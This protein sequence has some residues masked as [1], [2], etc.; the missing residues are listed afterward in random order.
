MPKVFLFVIE[1]DVS[2]FRISLHFYFVTPNRHPKAGGMR[3]VLDGVSAKAGPG[4]NQPKTPSPLFG[5]GSPQERQN[6][7]HLRSY[8]KDFVLLHIVS[9]GIIGFLHTNI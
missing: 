2:H 8:W 1:E 9:T 7:P 5:A 3:R 4:C 6:S